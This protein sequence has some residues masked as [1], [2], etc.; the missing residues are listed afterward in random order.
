MT[1]QFYKFQ[2]RA[3]EEALL[4][5]REEGGTVIGLPT[6]GGKTAVS[7]SLSGDPEGYTL[8]LVTKT[9]ILKWRDEVFKW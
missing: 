7:L 4:S 9:S 3:R 1:L 6:G 8:I 2:H 5:L